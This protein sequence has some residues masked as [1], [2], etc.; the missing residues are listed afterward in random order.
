MSADSKELIAAGRKVADKLKQ[1]VVGVLLGRD[2]K[3]HRNRGGAVRRGQGPHGRRPRSRRLLQ[4]QDHGHPRLPGEAEEALFF[5][6]PFD[7]AGEGPGSHGSPTGRRPGSRPTTYSSRSTITS[8]RAPSSPTRTS[9]YRSARTSGPG[10]PGS[11][12]R[13]TVRRC[14]R[15]GP[16]TSSRSRW[17][18]TARAVIEKL[19][20]PD[21]EQVLHCGRHGDKGT[22]QARGQPEGRTGRHQPGV[23]DPEGQDRGGPRP[24]RRA[25]NLR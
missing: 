9:S 3:Q 20:L 24:S 15:S 16:V 7:R 19:D 11:I 23:G 13:G 18:R 21:K 14:R 12:P 5:P 4:P 1:Q 8:W 6:V 17:T 10:S 2:L 25:T 22:A